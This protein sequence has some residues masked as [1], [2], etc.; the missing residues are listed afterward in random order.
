MVMFEPVVLKSH[1]CCHPTQLDQTCV[2]WGAVVV[3]RRQMETQ[4]LLMMMPS[5]V[6]VV[7][8]HLYAVVVG[9]VGYYSN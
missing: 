3:L 9:A 1:C 5:L 4:K 2:S 6:V 8:T 7:E